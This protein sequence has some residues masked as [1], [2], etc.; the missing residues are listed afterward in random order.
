MSEKDLKP[1]E[2]AVIQAMREHDAHG[3]GEFRVKTTPDAVTLE[4][5]KIIRFQKKSALTK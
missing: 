1:Q 4:N 3:H 5:G 2:R